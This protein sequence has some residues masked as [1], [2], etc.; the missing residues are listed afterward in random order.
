[1]RHH[2]A[3][4]R[5]ID[6]LLVLT[7]FSTHLYGVLRFV[8]FFQ[9]YTLCSHLTIPAQC[10]RDKRVSSRSRCNFSLRQWC[11]LALPASVSSRWHLDQPCRSCHVVVDVLRYIAPAATDV[12][13]AFTRLYGLGL[14]SSAS[15]CLQ[16]QQGTLD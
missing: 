15:S 4:R 11:A 10:W 16:Q 7:L 13:M 9:L 5:A 1:M 14:R 12:H 6:R 3:I 2:R 8:L